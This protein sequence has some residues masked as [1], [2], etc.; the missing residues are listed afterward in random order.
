MALRPNPIWM[1]IENKLRENK[2]SQADLVRRLHCSQSHVSALKLRLNKNPGAVHSPELLAKI[3][4]VFGVSY[5]WLVFG[6]EPTRMFGATDPCPSRRR[7]VAAIQRMD[8]PADLMEAVVASLESEVCEGG[9][10]G[11]PYW[12]ERATEIA[13]AI[14]KFKGT[15]Q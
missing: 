14:R 9:D 2:W 7:A 10:P 4:H 15:I 8:M 13:D 12:F 1:R 3:A 11:V 6:R 5:D